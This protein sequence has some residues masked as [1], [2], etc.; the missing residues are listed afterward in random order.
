MV[1]WAAPKIIE[2]HVYNDNF[3]KWP[4][5]AKRKLRKLIGRGGG[6]LG[7]FCRSGRHR[8]VAASIIFTYIFKHHGVKVIDKPRHI[9]VKGWG[10]LCRGIC[11]YCSPPGGKA[12]APAHALN[13]WNQIW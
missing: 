8:S 10:R 6:A 4:R 3:E 12:A 9:S 7:C 5:R 11:D 1:R 2:N 13:V